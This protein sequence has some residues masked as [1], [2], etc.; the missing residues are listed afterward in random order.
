MIS[1][2]RTTGDP[3]GNVAFEELSTT[4]FGDLPARVSRSATLDGGAVI[5]HYGVSH[6][7]R[8]FLIEAKITTAQKTT[9]E[10]LHRC[11]EN[12]ILSCGEGLFLG[13]I[14]TM[15]TSRSPFSMTFLIKE[16]LT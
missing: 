5:T 11:N 8:T 2:C 16:E 3:L 9:L 6:G 1:I 15:N 7:D 10:Y 12:L 13:A 4:D 14:S